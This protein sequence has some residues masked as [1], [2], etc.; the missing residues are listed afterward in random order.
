MATFGEIIDGLG[1]TGAKMHDD[2]L[3][4]GAVVLLKVIDHE[5]DVVLRSAW[6]DGLSWIERRG[7][8][9]VAVG[10]ER[11]DDHAL[12]QDDD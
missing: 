11:S 7:M 9:E 4:E 12:E 6:S 10:V 8:L 1:V 5:G 3:V 2:D